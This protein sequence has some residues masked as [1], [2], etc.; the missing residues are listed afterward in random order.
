MTKSYLYEEYIIDKDILLKDN[1]IYDTELR[2]IFNG[3]K[4]KINKLVLICKFEL[5]NS[6]NYILETKVIKYKDNEKDTSSGIFFHHYTIKENDVINLDLILNIICESNTTSLNETV[7]GFKD[8][9]NN[10]LSLKLWKDK[11]FNYYAGLTTSYIIEDE[12]FDF[13]VVGGGPSG[14]YSAYKISQENPDS[15][16][17]LLEDNPNTHEEYKSKGY[18]KINKWKLSQVDPDFQKSYSSDDNKTIWV[19]KGLG[20]GTL[21]FGLQYVNNISKNYEEWKNN[22]DVIDKDLN[23][24]KYS[25]EVVENNYKP[26]STWYE[27][28]E[29]L[30]NYF[31]NDNVNVYNNTIYS[32]DLDNLDRLLLGDLIKNMNN[33]KIQYNSKVDKLIFNNYTN[34]VVESVKTFDNKYY[35][36]NNII[37]C[38]GALE[39]PCILQRSDIDCGNKLY[40]HG[41]IAGL[42]YGKLNLPNIEP[43]KNEDSYFRLN[44]NNLEL[45]NEK[46]NRY[47]FISSGNRLP[48]EEIDNIYDFTEW[49][50][51]HPGGSSNIKKWR[52]NNNILVYP[53]NSSRWSTYKSNFT[54]V[55]KKNELIQYKNLPENLKS[56]ELFNEIEWEKNIKKNK[57]RLKILVLH[58]GG[59]NSEVLK[60]QVGMQN[61]MNSNELN[62]YEF[63][64]VNSPYK[65]GNWWP[66]PPS[67]NEPTTNINHAELSINYLKNFIKTNGPFY[68]ILGYSQGAAMS[69]VLLAYTD[70]KFEKVLLYN[71]YLP[72]THYGLMKTINEKKPLDSNPLIFLGKEDPFYTLGLEISSVFKDNIELKSDLAGH[73]LPSN[74]DPIFNKTIEYLR[75]NTNTDNNQIVLVDDLGFDN[76]K[77]ISHL[78]T[79]D[80]DFTW[81]TYYSTVPGLNNLL[82]LTHSQSVDLEGKGSVKISSNKNE[83]PKIILNH[84]GNNK[85]KVIDQIYDAYIKNHNFLTSNGYILLNPNPLENPI[86][87][88]FIENNLDSIYHYHGSCSI[89]EIVDENQKVYN[90]NNLY[91]GDI[92]VLSKPW[93]GSTSYAALNTG[94]NVSKNFLKKI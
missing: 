53:H 69:I 32:T 9:N 12:V 49:A 66:D 42:A 35:K 62:N 26:N 73:E 89:G 59:S 85:N 84:F 70:I 5:I 36:S 76:D 92:S 6:N 15:K 81:Q 77:I 21:H 80:N 31:N 37:L 30:E 38:C 8:L 4:D 44:A 41:A 3:K 13:I 79:R 91:I 19:G 55:G 71:G 23:P 10:T 72:K 93:G 52:N 28:K 18:D 94:L 65:D 17:L 22:Y 54:Y 47:V 56:E 74:N 51:Y 57:D 40:D 58:G 82:I 67:K 83:N 68:G 27:F 60:Y 86:D 25:Y 11:D 43:P 75:N 20:G 50:N 90:V 2:F 39:T 33:I 78:Q 7:C 46:S 61:L 45:I 87:K 64:F 48:S 16:I 63:V 29:N 24:Q 34:N 1:E 88:E 14:I